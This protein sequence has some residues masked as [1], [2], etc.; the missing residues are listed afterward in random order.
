[1]WYVY[2]HEWNIFM[3]NLFPDMWIF[4]LKSQALFKVFLTT[5]TGST[6]GAVREKGQTDKKEE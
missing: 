4:L 1:M 2:V 5:N 6:Y 3:G